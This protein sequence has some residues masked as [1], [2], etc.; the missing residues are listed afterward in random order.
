MLILIILVLC[1]FSF[2]LDEI[3]QEC[4]VIFL[5][6]FYAVIIVFSL[7]LN[8][9]IFSMFRKYMMLA[10][11]SFFNN[12]VTF[13]AKVVIFIRN[14]FRFLLIF[15]SHLFIITVFSTCFKHFAV[16]INN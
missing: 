4:L 12:G 15:F 5:K 7:Y 8:K 6:H 9:Q 1:V 10:D 13:H 14:N 2:L 16:F 11:F 3:D